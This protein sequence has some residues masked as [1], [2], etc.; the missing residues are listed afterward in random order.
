MSTSGD[1]G[2]AEEVLVLYG[3]QTGNSESAAHEISASIPSRLSS[4]GRPIA[5]RVMHLDDFLE[6]ERA[7]WT[8]LVV[9]V[10]SSY[11]VGHAPMGAQRFRDV[12]DEILDGDDD[13]S[14]SGAR[15]EHAGLLEG[16]T[17]AMIGLGDSNYSTFFEN[18]RTI[19]A[20][21]TA[22]G[23]RR[24]GDLGKADASG[25]G[26][27]EQHKVIERWVAGVWDELARV[28][29]SERPGREVLD[30]AADGTWALCLEVFPD[31]RPRRFGRGSGAAVAPLL[32]AALAVGAYLF[33]RR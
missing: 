13:G 30:A 19:D 9:I 18:P 23:A 32:G 8:R 29:A 1:G 21:M 12:C 33:V 15:K 20:A 11:G 14:A 3:S 7:A 28:V 6:V 24:V 27:D 4:P 22:A 16:V 17:Y 26:D 10:V 5:S 31:W 2:G 25:T